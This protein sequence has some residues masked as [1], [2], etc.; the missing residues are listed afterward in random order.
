M[1]P[2][3]RYHV[4]ERINGHFPIGSVSSG[5]DIDAVID[6]IGR[7]SASV[8]SACKCSD[9]PVSRLCYLC[10]AHFA[11]DGVFR[12]EGHCEL[13]LDAVT[14]QLA[15]AYSVLEENAEA[16]DLAARVSRTSISSA[17]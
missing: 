13:V 2:D 8:L 10:Y 16:F 14:R 17:T 9:C 4:C 6:L 1:T 11:A 7:Y 5:L 12:P 15:F 3:G